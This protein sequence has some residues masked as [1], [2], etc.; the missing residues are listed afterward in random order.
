MKVLFITVGFAVL[1]GVTF[2]KP[3][4]WERAAGDRKA[5]SETKAAI[6][7]FIVS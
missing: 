1:K 2:P 4:D 7:F 3:T 5:P 6:A